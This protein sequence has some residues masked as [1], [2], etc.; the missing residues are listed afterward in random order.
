MVF[1]IN[2]VE[3]SANNFEAFLEIAESSGNSTTSTGTV[4]SSSTTSTSTGKSGAL[5]LRF[6]PRFSSAA[7]VIGA[8]SAALL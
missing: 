3:S 8:L 7:L 4:T 1:A 5:G 2:A 6:S